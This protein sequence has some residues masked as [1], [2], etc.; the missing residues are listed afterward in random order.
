MPEQPP[1]F[2][3]KAYHGTEPYCFVSYSH[4]DSA[5]VFGELATI[6]KAGYRVYYD[7]GI[8][9]G[10]TWHDELANAIAGSTLFVLIVTRHSVAPAN[11]ARELNFALDRKIPILAIHYD[12]VELSPGLQLALGNRQAIIRSRFTDSDFHERVVGAIGE[13]LAADRGAV[14]S[15]SLAA[16]VSG[17]HSSPPVS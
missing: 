5:L 1:K 3:V 2:M 14:A 9:P 16:G 8:H 7:E 4:A 6:A 11:C 15:A 17:C 13:H 10:H 12:D